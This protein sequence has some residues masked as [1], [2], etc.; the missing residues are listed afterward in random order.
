MFE[1]IKS[2]KTRLSSEDEDNNNDHGGLV[3]QEAAP[4]LKRPSMYRVVLMNDDFTPMEFVVEVLMIF[5]NMNQEKA[6]Q[7]MLSVHTQGK[8]LCGVFSRDVAETK[9]TQVNQYA[10]DNKHP[11]LSEVEAV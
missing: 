7:V 10:R 9:A 6:T 4:K 8:G 5:F 2:V 3:T 1:V 11:L